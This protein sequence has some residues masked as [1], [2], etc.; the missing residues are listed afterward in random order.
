M[1]DVWTSAGYSF[2]RPEPAARDF[3]RWL[4]RQL[5]AMY[6]AAALEPLPADIR[7]LVEQIGAEPE[8][9]PDV[10]RPGSSVPWPALL[11]A[12]ALPGAD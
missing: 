3:D 5:R 11:A 10:A 6:A 7:R 8:T 2:V 1:G 9:L 4:D 12:A